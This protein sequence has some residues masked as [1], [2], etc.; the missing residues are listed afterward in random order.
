MTILGPWA[1]PGIVDAKVPFGWDV[2]HMPASPNSGQR[3]TCLYVDHYGIYSDTNHP[4]ASWEYAKW[5]SGP[6]GMMMWAAIW[7]ARSICPVKAVCES[8]VWLNYGGCNGRLILDALEY[9]HTPPIN[10]GNA[11][12]AENI[13]RAEL[14]LVIVEQQTVKEAVKNIC[15]KISPI[16]LESA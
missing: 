4:E 7:G 16:L 1:R 12:E 8:P 6:E 2:A 3:G 11:M 5:V 9:A 14:D 13:W 10:W 15:D